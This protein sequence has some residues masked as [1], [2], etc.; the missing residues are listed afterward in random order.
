MASRW[1]GGHWSRLNQPRRPRPELLDAIE[2]AEHAFGKQ[3]GSVLLVGRQ[4]VISEQVPVAGVEE[5]R[6]VRGRLTSARA[7][8]RSPSPA[9]SSSASMPWICTGTSGPC[10]AELGDRDTGFEQQRSRRTGP[11][12]GQHLRREDTEGNPA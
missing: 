3:R 10:A 2:E 1:T 11:G 8:W 9:K 12:L 5:Q 6:G 7:A 4:T